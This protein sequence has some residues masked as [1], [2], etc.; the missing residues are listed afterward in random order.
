MTRGHEKFDYWT[1]T[2]SPKIKAFHQTINLLIKN[3]NIMKFESEFLFVIK[4]F[5]FKSAKSNK[6]FASYLLHILL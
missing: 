5:S 3:N 1:Q 6:I 4:I 2:V